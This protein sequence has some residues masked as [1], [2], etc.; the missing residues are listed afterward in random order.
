M[1]DYSVIAEV[2]TTTGPGVVIGSGGSLNI[3]SGTLKLTGPAN[4]TGTAS[5]SGLL[6]VGAS[7]SVGAPG[8]ASVSV[9][10]ASGTTI[11]IAQGIVRVSATAVTTSGSC[12]L[13]AGTV[14]GQ[15]VTLINESANNILLSGNILKAVETVSATRGAQFCWISADT[16][17][18][19]IGG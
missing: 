13:A 9:A 6:T 1:Q 12:T 18:A 5:I 3:A 2:V 11:P 7:Q 4:I 17:W 15:L 16:K 14:D 8:T 19:M 10:T